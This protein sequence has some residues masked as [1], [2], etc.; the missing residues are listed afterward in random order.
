VGNRRSDARGPNTLGKP[1][2]RWGP[3][4][5]REG[6][7]PYK[8]PARPDPAGGPNFADF[9]RRATVAEPVPPPHRP[10]ASGE[11]EAEE[12]AEHLF[13]VA[14]PSFSPWAPSRTA[15]QERES[16]G[17]TSTL[18]L[19][20]NRTSA[21]ISPFWCR[22]PSILAAA[23]ATVSTERDWSSPTNLSSA[24]GLDAAGV[25]AASR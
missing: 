10:H 9:R 15:G 4:S 3:S 22:V 20:A 23:M 12:V 18:L 19:R 11:H 5:V 6:P 16:A 21:F 25:R 17:G 14:K 24:C 7:A 13:D 2:P 8:F 1:V